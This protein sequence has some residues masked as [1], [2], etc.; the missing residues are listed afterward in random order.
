MGDGW[1]RLVWRYPRHD[2][3]ARRHGSP[4]RFA[5]FE[6]AVLTAG[7]VVHWAPVGFCPVC[8]TGWLAG[9][10]AGVCACAMHPVPRI[11][12]GAGKV[13]VR[14]QPVGGQL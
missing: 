7:L 8:M 10:L 2:T 9:W 13:T 5:P 12:D 11:L 1:T 4:R 14:L 3:V 6:M